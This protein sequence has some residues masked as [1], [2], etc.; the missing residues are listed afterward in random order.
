MSDSKKKKIVLI[1]GSTDGIGKLTA[2][3][4]AGQNMSVLIHGR[5]IEKTQNVVREV[6]SKSGNQ[7][8][9]GYTADFSSLE[10]VRQL[11]DQIL[12][13]Y[14]ELNILINN[15][16]AG[17]TDPR[18]SK[19]GYELRFTV[20]YLAPFLLTNLLLPALR[21]GAPAR[22]I[23]VSSVGQHSINFED[24]M[25]EKNF[26]AVTAYSQS[27][28]ALIMFTFDLAEELKT[29]NITVNSLHPGTYLN[30]NM[31]RRAGIKPWGTPESGAD[32]VAF[33]AMSESLNRTT[34]KYFNV[35]TE[36]KAL[37]QSYDKETRKKLRE[38]SI[39]L[40]KLK[41]DIFLNSDSERLN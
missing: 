33:L 34:G 19:E 28:L 16:G 14:P 15:A 21:K 29:E 37:A 26:N 25:M 6:I 20:N 30:T 4:L 38:L 10:E 3:K 1:T 24:I 35:L 41:Q 12:I 5:D 40:T 18:Y 11:A 31:V 39:R 13:E 36:S 23:N 7:N 8:I 27:K 17:Y 32:A 9:K 22:I 2:L